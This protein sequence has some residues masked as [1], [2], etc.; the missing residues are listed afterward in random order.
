MKSHAVEEHVVRGNAP[1][2]GAGLVVTGAVL[3]AGAALADPA[4]AHAPVQ[5]AADA[6]A[7]SAGRL[8]AAVAAAAG[9]AGVFAGWRALSRSGRRGTPP[10]RGG[11]AALVA[12]LT[13]VV[14]GGVV[15][16]TASGGLGTGNGLGGAVVA[17][18]LGLTGAALGGL[19]LGRSRRR[20]APAGPSRR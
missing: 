15:A 16:A 18:V 7:W 1:S 6:T 19:A 8:G 17:V 14:V 2:I 9:L 13:A 11:A 5:Q 3:A 20:A 4:A 10:G 12:G